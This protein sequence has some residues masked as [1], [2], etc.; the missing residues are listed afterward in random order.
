MNKKLTAGAV[1]SLPKLTELSIDGLTP[2]KF[3]VERWFVCTVDNTNEFN[4]GHAILSPL[5]EHNFER[6]APRYQL[7]QQYFPLA[8]VVRNMLESVSFD[9]VGVLKHPEITA[10][11]VTVC[12]SKVVV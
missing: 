8:L 7:R 1:F 2:L 10:T 9:S 4:T 11:T 3:E 12:G 6:K 5:W